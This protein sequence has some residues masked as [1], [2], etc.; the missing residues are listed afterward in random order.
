MGT[1]LWKVHCNLPQLDV[2]LQISSAG[3]HQINIQ[4]ILP[5]I[6]SGIFNSWLS[7]NPGKGIQI[8]CLVHPRAYK[9]LRLHTFKH[10][11]PQYE[12]RSCRQGRT[13]GDGREG[14]RIMGDGGRHLPQADVMLPSSH[15]QTLAPGNL[16]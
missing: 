10:S 5:T 1:K 3:V 14:D 7:Q 6:I 16:R 15:G 13:K 2:M 12:G 4:E 11:S 8:V 9:G